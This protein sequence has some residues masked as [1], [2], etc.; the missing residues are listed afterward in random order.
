[1]K[2]LVHRIYYSGEVYKMSVVTIENGRVMDIRPFET[3]TEGTRFI[4]GAIRLVPSV[5]GVMIVNLSPAEEQE[6]RHT[7]VK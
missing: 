7:A 2:I 5:D 3:E 4:S 1:M 6:L